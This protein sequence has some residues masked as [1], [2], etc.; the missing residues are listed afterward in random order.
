M[1]EGSPIIRSHMVGQRCLANSTVVSDE[2]VITVSLSGDYQL[3]QMIQRYD[4]SGL[5]TVRQKVC[6]NNCVC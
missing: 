4:L 6:G 5:H 3:D 2:C 1:E